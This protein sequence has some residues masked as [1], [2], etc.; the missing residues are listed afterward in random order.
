MLLLFWLRKGDPGKEL[1]IAM[2]NCGG[3]HKHNIVF[4][5]TPHLLEMGHFGTIKFCFKYAAIPRRPY[6][7]CL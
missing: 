2:D 3:Q 4:R 6:Q 5:L 7:E 1:V